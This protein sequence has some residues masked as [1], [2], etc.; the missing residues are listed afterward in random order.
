MKQRYTLATEREARLA[1]LKDHL[2][3]LGLNADRQETPVSAIVAYLNREEGLPVATNK[4]LNAE[5]TLEELVAASV[6]PP[7]NPPG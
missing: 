1:Q 6:K 3:E 7:E 2:A 5:T 4:N